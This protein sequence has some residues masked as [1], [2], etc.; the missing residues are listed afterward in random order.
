M[1]YCH[2]GYLPNDMECCGCFVKHP[3]NPLKFVCNEC[4]HEYY[5]IQ[6]WFIQ[7]LEGFMFRL[8]KRIEKNKLGGK[9]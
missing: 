9:D 5:K 3:K 1:I 7:W 6:I 2:N 4:G 8:I